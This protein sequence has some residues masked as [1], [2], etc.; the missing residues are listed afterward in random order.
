MPLKI[1]CDKNIPYAIINSLYARN[2]HVESVA[3]GAADGAIASYARKHKF[4]ILTFD[5]DFANILVY[6][7]SDYFGIVVIRISPPLLQSIL[8]ALDTLF[9]Q[10]QSSTD[11][12]KKLLILDPRGVRVWEK[13]N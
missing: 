4:I 8:K 7:P 12:R 9:S 13:E 1:L 3:R 2:F 5:S 6:P 10:F 11:F